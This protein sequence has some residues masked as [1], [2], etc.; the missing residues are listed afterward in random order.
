MFVSSDASGEIYVVVKDDND[1]GN[2]SG[3]GSGG[4]SSSGGK[5]KSSGAEMRRRR[6]GFVVGTVGEGGGAWLLAFLFVVL[7]VL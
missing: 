2:G 1:S 6:G 5:P 3:S 7:V 4:S